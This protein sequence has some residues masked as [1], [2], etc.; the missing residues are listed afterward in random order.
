M[1]R[2]SHY[3]PVWCGGGGFTPLGLPTGTSDPL[4]VRP[5]ACGTDHSAAQ[6]PHKNPGAKLRV[7]CA[8]LYPGTLL[9]LTREGLL[10]PYALLPADTRSRCSLPLHSV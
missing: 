8:D 3:G 5:G 6:T 4:Q 2:R 7:P 10:L 9:C 1:T